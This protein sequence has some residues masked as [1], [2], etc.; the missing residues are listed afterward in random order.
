[1]WCSICFKWCAKSKYLD[2]Q[3]M[4][5]TK[6]KSLIIIFVNFY[7]INCKLM[8]FI[9]IS[10]LVQLYPNNFL[11]V[12]VK[13]TISKRLSIMSIFTLNISPTIFFISHGLHGLP[14][15]VYFHLTLNKI[16]HSANKNFHEIFNLIK[17]RQVPSSYNKMTK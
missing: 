12:T 14:L 2:S 7:I 5:F 11:N 1:M 6:E 13:S 9:W 8:L 10:D 15:V 16:H 3:G 4:L 17:W